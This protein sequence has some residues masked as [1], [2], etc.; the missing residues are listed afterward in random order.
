MLNDD[1]SHLRVIET[2]LTPE[3]SGTAES[4]PW[5]WKK[6]DEIRLNEL[7][8]YDQVIRGGKTIQLD[9]GY[10][11]RESPRQGHLATRRNSILTPLKKHGKIV[12]AF[13]MSCPELSGYFTPSVKSL[14]Q[15]ISTALELT[16]EYAV[17]K[18]A[19]EDL[20][21]LSEHLQTVRE[22]ERTGIAREIHDEL[23]Q[24]LT[25]LKMGLSWMKDKLSCDQ[26]QLVDRTES[27]LGLTDTTIQSV[28]KICT[29][30]RPGLLDD[31]GLA[32]AIEWQAGE[33]ENR[34]GIKCN[35][36]MDPEDITLD[37]DPSTAIFRI[38]Q[39][40]LTNVA[41]HANATEVEASLMERNGALELRVKDNGRGI[42]KEQIQKPRS[43]GLLGIRERIHNLGGRFQIKGAKNKGTTLMVVIPLDS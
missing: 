34:T 32:A 35:V 42:T 5:P 2:S 29:E 11:M 26:Q 31:L 28:K 16:D 36:K 14:A 38:F 1:G 6:G 7:P 24:A 15:H 18:R 25:V 22:E 8:A 23:G 17:R 20:R 9:S 39:E 33:F 13:A 21:N 19:E 27:M 30:L 12:G 40:A 37:R 10:V 41:R 3:T 43:F 4:S